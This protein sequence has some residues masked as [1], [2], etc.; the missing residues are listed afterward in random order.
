MS[1]VQN[2]EVYNDKSKRSARR[3]RDLE[4]LPTNSTRY[5][6]VES[7]I[8]LGLRILESPQ[9]KNSLI[10]IAT[11][12]VQ[13]RDFPPGDRP[14][15]PH[16][17]NRPLAEMPR[18]V[19]FFFGRLRSNFPVVLLCDIAGEASAT[20]KDWGT[21]MSQYDPQEASHF[22]FNKTIINNM[23]Y[24]RHQPP[25]VTGD[26]YNCFKF[27]MAITIAHEIVH[28]LTGF[29]TGTARPYTPPGVSL[30]NYGNRNMGESGRY[31]ESILLGGVVE[32]FEDGNDPLQER[33]A[34]RP[35]LIEDSRNNVP[36]QLV[37]TTY[38]NNFLNG[39]KFS[40]GRRV[41]M[42]HNVKANLRRFLFPYPH[43]QP[44]CANY[45]Q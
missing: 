16:I 18:W 32:F 4:L 30:G 19:D 9:G 38:I 1:S 27:Q 31:W 7:V 33:Q 17:Y 37:S 14:P 10:R 26:N 39:R 11:E 20:K 36:A 29:L 3:E 34:G 5:R 21:D 45:S 6:V 40:T 2:L 23:I 43:F 25:N 8:L 35:Y 44:C 42:W 24:V 28:L 12:V 22:E 13:Q 41:T 15:V